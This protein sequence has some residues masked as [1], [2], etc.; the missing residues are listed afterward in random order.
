MTGIMTEASQSTC[1]KGMV[2]D[3]YEYFFHVDESKMPDVWNKLNQR[4]TFIDGQIF[5]YRVE[6]GSGHK[7]GSFE[8][9][10]L[11]IHHGPLLSVHGAIGK[12]TS[13]YRSLNYFYGSYVLSFRIIR[14]ILLEFSREGDQLKLRLTS[15]VVPWMLPLWRSGNNFFWKFFGISFLLPKE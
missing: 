8:T 1:P 14:P 2:E 12:V 3:N 10:E 7:E 15:Y 6:F 9:G 5:P 4:Q 13:H 11:N